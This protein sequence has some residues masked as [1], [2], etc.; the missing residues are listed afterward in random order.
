MR[1]ESA[2]RKNYTGLSKNNQNTT[3][4]SG[5]NCDSSTLSNKFINSKPEGLQDFSKLVLNNILTQ[6]IELDKDEK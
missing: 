3:V 2:G 6:F 5:R 1:E 4:V